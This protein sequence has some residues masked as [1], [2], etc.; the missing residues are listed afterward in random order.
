MLRATFVLAL[1][2]LGVTSCGKEKRDSGSSPAGSKGT[3]GLSVLTLS[4]PFFKDISETMSAEGKK[5]GFEVITVSGEFKPELQRDQVRD[6]IVRKC[7][8]IVLTPCDSKAVGTAIAEAN[9]A[10]IPVFTADIKS[11]ADGP[12]VIA[13]IATDNLS[14][15]REAA[16]AMIEALGTTGG[17]VAIIHHP[18][19][20]SCILRVRG[21]REVMEEHNAGGKG[22]PIQVVA[23]LAGGGG[24]E[25][26]FKAAEDALQAHPDLAG[27]FAINDPSAL[28]ARAALEK[29][30]RTG[31]KIVGFDGQIDGKQA[32]KD[33][34][35][36]ADPVQ[37]PEEIGRQTMSA[38]V[39]HFAGEPVRPEILIPTTLY[40]QSDG[41][42]D[43][44]L[45]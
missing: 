30:D 35:I 28:G 37:S 33:G 10:G 5:H 24:K 14:G 40:R 13:H 26:S 23:E 43:P 41:A 8:A 18:V 32:I 20:E 11:L 39:N 19:A 15:G 25:G 45:R 17:K 6:F 12:K 2:T 7:A 9:A 21:F 36:Y 22:V 42:N 38:I 31:I 4:N 34:K 29:A 3:I 16:K 27:I 1:A 44:A